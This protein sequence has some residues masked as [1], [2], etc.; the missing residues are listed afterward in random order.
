MANNA[1]D[2]MNDSAGGEMNIGGSITSSEYEQNMD[3]SEQLKFERMLIDE[4]NEL[5]QTAPDRGKL[6]F[7]SWMKTMDVGRI[8]EQAL[9]YDDI[10]NS[11]NGKVRLMNMPGGRQIENAGVVQKLAHLHTGRIEDIIEIALNTGEHSYMENAILNPD[12]SGTNV[13][14][15]TRVVHQS[16]QPPF[17]PVTNTGE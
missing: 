15:L 5:Y 8:T 10:I 12:G 6:D 17:R 1:F 14:D 16:K 9:R 4:F 11:N 13:T 7:K 2:A 3:P